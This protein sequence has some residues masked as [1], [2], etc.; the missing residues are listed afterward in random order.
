M[1]LALKHR[2]AVEVVSRDRLPR[3]LRTDPSLQGQETRDPLPI[4]NVLGIIPI[5]ELVSRD[6][7]V[8]HRRDQHTLRHGR[9]S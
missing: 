8:I 9:S 1:T 3:V 4:R 2:E 5:V 6:I 7:R